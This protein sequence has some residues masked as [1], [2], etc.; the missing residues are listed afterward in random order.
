MEFPEARIYEEA[1]NILLHEPLCPSC[2]AC[3]P[4]VAAAADDSDLNSPDKVRLS[5]SFPPFPSPSQ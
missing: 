5:A 3:G 4:S 1:M 2:Q